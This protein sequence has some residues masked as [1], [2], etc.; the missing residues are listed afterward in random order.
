MR[1]SRW[2]ITINP[3]VVGKTST[4]MERRTRSMKTAIS[5]LI[6]QAQPVQQTSSKNALY[7]NEEVKAPKGYSAET[8]A[9]TGKNKCYYFIYQKSK[10]PPP[11]DAYFDAT[12]YSDNITPPP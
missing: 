11:L 5:P 10:A 1:N 8:D 9:A 12:M 2:S 6:F 7:R 3:A 4:L